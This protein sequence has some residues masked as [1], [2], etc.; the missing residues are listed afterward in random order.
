MDFI[1][2]K[3]LRGYTTPSLELCMLNIGDV[4]TTSYP[5]SAADGDN[6]VNYSSIWNGE[7]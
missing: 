4:V 1:Q 2:N 6:D 5:F 7:V 3:Q